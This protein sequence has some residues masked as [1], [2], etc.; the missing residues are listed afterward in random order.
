MVI[1]MSSLL[2]SEV[3]INPKFFRGNKNIYL[4]FISTLHI[5][6]TQVIGIL[7]KICLFHIANIMAMW[8]SPP[9]PPPPPPCMLRVKIKARCTNNGNVTIMTVWFEVIA[10]ASWWLHEMET[11]SVLP[12]LCEG[13]PFTKGQWC[14]ALMF[15]LMCAWPEQMA[16]QTIKLLVIWDALALIVTSL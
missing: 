2:G 12:A 4:H 14:G 10:S 3:V 8:N 5:D 13:N 16:G 9:P 6:M 11:F 1:T 7:P 15:S